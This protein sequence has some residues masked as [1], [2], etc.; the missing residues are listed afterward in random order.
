M[1]DESEEAEASAAERSY[2]HLAEQARKRLED[3]ARTGMKAFKPDEVR[4][5]LEAANLTYWFELNARSFDRK[6]DGGHCCN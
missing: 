4:M 2:V 6:A 5:F 3:I 1:A